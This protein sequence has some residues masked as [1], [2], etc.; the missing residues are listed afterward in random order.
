M[1][2]TG[3]MVGIA[4]ASICNLFDLKIAVVGGGVAL[5]FGPTFFHAAQD[6]LDEHCR[7][8]FTKGARIM[9]ARLGD[10]SPL[11]GAAA[12]GWRG[13]NLAGM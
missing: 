12:I 10:Q 11:I 13:L 9:P 1:Q 5:G 4:V 3:K 2:R 7:L 8:G 6:V